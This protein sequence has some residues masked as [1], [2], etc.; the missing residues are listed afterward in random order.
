MNNKEHENMRERTRYA[1]GG[2]GREEAGGVEEVVA[3]VK[4]SVTL[5]IAGARHHHLLAAYRCAEPFRQ[6][7]NNERTVLSEAKAAA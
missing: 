4:P 3:I 5:E 1:H 7:E 6:V 2:L